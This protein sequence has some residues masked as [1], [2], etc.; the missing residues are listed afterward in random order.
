M[1]IIHGLS[2]VACKAILLMAHY[3]RRRRRRASDDVENHDR[4]LVSYADFITLLFAFFVVMYAISSVNEGKY[5]VMSESIVS[6]F[7]N[8]PGSASGAM[9]MVNPN[10]PAPTSLSPQPNSTRVK[11]DSAR[12]VKKEHLRNLAKELNQAL[13]PLMAEG[14]VRMAE[15]ALGLTIDISASALF[16][17]GEARLDL[18]AVRALDAVGRVLAT[19]DFPVRVEGHTDNV[20]ITNPQFPSNWELSAARAASVVRLFID[21]NVDPR[22]LTA[23]GYADQRPLADNATP[24]GRQ[25]N[26]RVAITIESPTPDLAV[27]V[28]LAE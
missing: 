27:D 6:A 18:G 7:R 5:R 4:W 13:A 9:V 11:T 12:L 20:P 8:E 2:R 24:E 1:G 25:K 3:R 15:G 19:A 21:T 23:T 14:K 10:N 28:P 26:R 17:P 16:L 22:R